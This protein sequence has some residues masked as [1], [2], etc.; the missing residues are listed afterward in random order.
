MESEQTEWPNPS[1]N[2]WCWN[3]MQFWNI[4]EVYT[5]VNGVWNKVIIKLIKL[6]FISPKLIKAD[7]IGSHYTYYLDVSVTE[8]SSEFW[9]SIPHLLFMLLYIAIACG[10]CADPLLLSILYHS[11]YVTSSS[12]SFYIVVLCV[13][14]ACH[15]LLRI[16]LHPSLPPCA[17]PT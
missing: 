11:P 3:L 6:D 15:C 14:C 16:V 7:C 2:M 8:T 10:P 9:C 17:L 1:C 12:C 13:S 5:Q 4:G